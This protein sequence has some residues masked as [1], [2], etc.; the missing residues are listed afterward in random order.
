[1]PSCVSKL[2]EMLH[3]WSS[4]RGFLSTEGNVFAKVSAMVLMNC[5]FSSL[6]F[7]T[8]AETFHNGPRPVIGAV[9]RTFLSLSFSSQPVS[10]CRQARGDVDF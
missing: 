5:K 9:C 1:M 7:D 3:S 8:I 10:A 4:E 6:S 2:D